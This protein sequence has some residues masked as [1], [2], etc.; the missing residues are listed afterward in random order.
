MAGSAG[1]GSAAAVRAM[2][3]ADTESYEGYTRPLEPLILANRERFLALP[4]AEAGFNLRVVDF[5]RTR[6][7][8]TVADGLYIDWVRV[9]Y[10]DPILYANT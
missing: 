6:G 3:A 2:V 10:F 7:F 1:Q 4:I 5:L 8:E 9:E